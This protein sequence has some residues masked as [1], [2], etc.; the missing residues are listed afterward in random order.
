MSLLVPAATMDALSLTGRLGVNALVQVGTGV[1]ALL[2]LRGRGVTLRQLGL[3]T[4]RLGSNIL[5]GIATYCVALPLVLGLGAIARAIFHESSAATP[6]P[7]LPMLTAH[8]DFFGRFL[9]FSMVSLAA[10][11][12]EEVFFRGTL[13]TGLRQRQA[14]L[15]AAALSG[16]VFAMLHPM[17]D[18]LPIFGL[19]FAFACARELRQSLVPCL[20]AHF[21]QNTMSFVLLTLLFR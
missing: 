1:V 13:F 19:G 10:P 16:V 20:V 7:M 12:F 4:D 5:Y 3:H 15:A 11:F 8:H 21:L 17:A 9:I 2:Y 6:N 18:W 14:F